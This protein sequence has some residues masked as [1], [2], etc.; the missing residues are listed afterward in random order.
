MADIEE[1][2]QLAA[3]REAAG[4]PIDEDAFEDGVAPKDM[5]TAHHIRANSSI[6][7]LNKILG[8]Y[9]EPLRADFLPQSRSFLKLTNIFFDS[10]QQ[11][12]NS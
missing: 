7:H 6:M 9:S 5:K 3:A 11:R 8:E 10:G 12:R 1:I 4:Q 2:K